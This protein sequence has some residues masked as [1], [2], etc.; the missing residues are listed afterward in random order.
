MS[1]KLRESEEYSIQS[2]TRHVPQS[3]VELNFAEDRYQH[4]TE[5]HNFYN[6]GY[7]LVQQRRT[8]RR[9]TGSSID[10]M[11]SFR[12]RNE[13]YR[14]LAKNIRLKKSII[15]AHKVIG[16]YFRSERLVLEVIQDPDD[17][18]SQLV[19]FIQTNLSPQEALDKLHKFD[20]E[21]WL[22]TSTKGGINRKLCITIEFR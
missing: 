14:I 8:R 1:C 21:W 17:R 7:A 11:F 10:T 9:S 22:N 2:V 6:M 18:S 15:D 4:L 20:K 19:I 5:M 12:K 3:Q 13:V 16:R